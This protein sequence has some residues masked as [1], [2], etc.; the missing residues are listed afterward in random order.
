[1]R[2][3]MVAVIA[4]CMLA[5]CGGGSKEPAGTATEAAS[6][7][8]AAAPAAPANVAPPA[9]AMCGSCHSVTPHEARIGPSLFGVFGRKSGSE[10]GYEYSDAMKNAG[11]TWDE[12]TLDKYLTDPRIDVPGTKMTFAGI[13]DPVRRKAVIDYLKTLK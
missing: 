6:P 4:G 7:A 5:S 2:R 11:K 12:P 10:P 8:A 9:F 3:Y 1:M 13:E